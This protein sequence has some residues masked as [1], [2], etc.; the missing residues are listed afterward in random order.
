MTKG[1]VILD[2]YE[3][4]VVSLRMLIQEYFPD[5]QIHSTDNPADALRILDEHDILLVLADD[6][7]ARAASSGFFD[8]AVAKAPNACHAMLTTDPRDD[9]NAMAVAAC[10]A[11]IV[12]SKPMDPEWFV[13][14]LGRTL[15]ASRAVARSN[16]QSRRRGPSTCRTEGDGHKFS[17]TR[18]SNSGK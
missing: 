17:W 4:L 2:A 7:T 14:F 8:D 3:D 9:V 16:A 15:G 11:D 6:R 1:V 12:V 18:S 10:G 5:V 13:R